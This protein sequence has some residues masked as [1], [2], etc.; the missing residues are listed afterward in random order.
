MA[1]IQGGPSTEAE[2][3]R[4]SG[5][6]LL[7][8][9]A[10][11]GIAA[12]AFELTQELA[13][14]LL[15]WRPDVA[16]PVAHGAQGEDGCL[17]GLLEVLGIPY[18]GSGVLSSALAFDK[19]RTKSVLDAQG[20]PVPQGRA[21]TDVVQQRE[22]KELLLELRKQL[23]PELIVKPQGGGSTIG[24]T[25][26]LED[27]GPQNLQEA[28]QEAFAFDPVVLVERYYQ[29]VELTCA[30]WDQENGPL[31]FSPT[32]IQSE[33][34]DWYD[35]SAKYA[36]GGS[37]HICPA[38]LESDVL[39]SLQKAAVT[40]HRALGCR[41][42]SRSD[43]ILQKDGSFVVLEVNTLPGFTAMSL[44]P[45]AAAEAGKT[46]EELVAGFAHWAHRRGST[47][48]A[49]GRALPA[50]RAVQGEL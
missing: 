28:L 35:F 8:A 25:R 2:V 43:F 29:G 19:D 15:A 16:F 9:F 39:L 6:A 22:P 36:Q 7:D 20:L 47:R 3:S 23:G 44:Y 1:V 40:A 31:A 26:L 24:I 41:D 48:R 34:S 27:A 50:G 42:L 33:V 5:R 21:L 4:A 10:R 38:P 32:L 11:R 18:V 46:F 45:E 13:S 30:V 49:E 37:R 17:Q 14:E 12:Q